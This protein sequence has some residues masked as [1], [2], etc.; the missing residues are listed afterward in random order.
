MA[1]LAGRAECCWVAN[2]PETNFLE[3]TGAQDCD[4]LVVGGGI[5]GLTAALS[6][7]E[8]RNTNPREG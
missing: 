2:A 8:A 1:E 4:V 5:V 7:L 3:F 6:L